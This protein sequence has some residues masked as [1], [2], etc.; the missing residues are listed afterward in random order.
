MRKKNLTDTDGEILA[1]SYQ[2]AYLVSYKFHL[3][4]FFFP[5]KYPSIFPGSQPYQIVTQPKFSTG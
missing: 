3:L 2:K 4:Y 1:G 5:F